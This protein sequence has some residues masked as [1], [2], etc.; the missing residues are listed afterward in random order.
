MQEYETRKKQQRLV[1]LRFDDVSRN[2]NQ[3][4]QT[5]VFRRFGQSDPSFTLRSSARHPRAPS[6]QAGLLLY[7]LC[8][9]PAPPRPVPP[10]ALHR[11]PCRSRPE[12]PT[13]SAV[14]DPSAL[15][16]C[17]ET[18]AGRTDSLLCQHQRY[19][20]VERVR[21]LSGARRKLLFLVLPFTCRHAMYSLVNLLLA[22]C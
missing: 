18:P 6:V 5:F 16:R 9:R 15:S 1:S 8:T 19:L 7:S 3:C 14:P 22:C 17:L 12:L 13:E 20:S 10:P 2:G 11:S 4:W 21:H